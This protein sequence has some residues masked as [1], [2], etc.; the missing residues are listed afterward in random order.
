MSLVIDPGVRRLGMF[1][2]AFDPPHMAHR[3]LAAA[4]IE[5]YELDRLL[6]VPTGSAWHKARPLSAARHRLAMCRLAF[7]GL[8][9][10]H[11]DDRETR[12]QGPSYTVDTLR[13]LQAQAPQ[14]QLFLVVGEDQL[15]AF[16]SWRESQAILR[17]ATLLVAE[18]AP[19]SG[20][21]HVEH[22]QPSPPQHAVPH[23]R[24]SLPGMPVSATALR[25]Q[26]AAGAPPESLCPMV[27]PAVARYISQHQLYNPSI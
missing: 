1:G 12:R 24:L 8:A 19:A 22:A 20:A 10:V 26:L 14:A 15:A 3:A 5:Q 27:A 9:G 11:L 23:L 7:E 17:L 16:G 18:R 25:A 21:M 13:E 2:G 4:A 6:L